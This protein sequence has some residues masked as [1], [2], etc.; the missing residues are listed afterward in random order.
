MPDREIL[1][2][3]VI[4]ELQLL[5]IR[6]AGYSFGINVAKVIEVLPTVAITA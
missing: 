2:E 3:S 1:F 6:V 5:V 4:G